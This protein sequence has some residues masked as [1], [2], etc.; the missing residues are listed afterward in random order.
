M[1]E[2]VISSEDLEMMMT[3]SETERNEEM[4][5]SVKKKKRRGNRAVVTWEKLLPRM[6]LRVLLVEADD[7]TRQIIA[8]LLR[9]C[10][11]KVVAVPDGLKAWEM[12]KRRPCDIDLILTE[13]DLPLISGY[14]LLTLIMEHDVCKNIPVIMMSSQDSISTVYKCMLQGAADYL[15][16]PIRRNEL[17]NL[18]QH[19]WR[20]QSSLA[21]GNVSREESVGQDKAEATSQ[22]NAA[23]NR[24]SGDRACIQ[25]NKEFT[26]KGGGS[27]SSCTKPD[28]E[29][30]SASVENV[31]ELLQPEWGSLVNM[32]IGLGSASA[33][34]T[35]PNQM[36]V[37]E[38]TKADSQRKNAEI[39]RESFEGSHFLVK[40][41]REAIDFM[42]T[43]ASRSSSV[44]NTK[45]KFDIF[46]QLDLCLSRCHSSGFEIQGAED[47]RTL[48]HSNASA[49]TRYNNRPLENVHT[50]WASIP[51]QKELGAYSER[52]FSSNV[53]G[54]NSD[55]PGPPSSPER[56]TV[57]PAICQRKESEVAISFPEQRLLSLQIPDDGV[58]FNNVCTSYGSI[59]PPIVSKQSGVSTIPSPSS[60]SHPEPD[61]EMDPFR[62]SNFKSNSDHL[63][64]RLV[65]REN[66]A[67]NLQKH[68]NMLNSFDDQGHI[69]PTA[70]QSAT[71]S[72]YNSAGSY[73]NIGYGSASGS[74]S[75]ADQVAKVRTAVERINDGF[76]LHNANSHRSI[77]REA[78]L[79]KFRLKRKDR[80]YEKKVRYESRK[81]LA[82]QRPRVKGQFVRQWQ[83]PS[84]ETEQ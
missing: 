30:E 77:Q 5:E 43:S 17:R 2:A 26:E 63:Y 38:D 18:W 55:A 52:K 12:L 7:S 47:G 81:K 54:Y 40:S 3:E 13:V 31:R 29:A 79:N 27:Q 8:A 50:S 41:S 76:L 65:Q 37:D 75:N 68:D 61:C 10:S 14:A 48:R 56:P 46:P 16:K 70:D 51:N 24:A 73:L 71:S 64:G 74:N 20:R 1:G 42:G 34:C 39:T 9:K 25:N 66:E 67:S 33:A 28:M 35:D 69:S 49:F 58:G 32:P 6:A 11:Y 53:T 4:E 72:F 15:V 22:N 82:E 78:A 36:A 60:G 44:D 19:V 21:R 83:P 62:A 80:C 84:A 57:S 45:R 59:L 23:S